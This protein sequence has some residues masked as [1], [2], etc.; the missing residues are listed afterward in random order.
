MTISSPADEA[1]GLDPPGQ[2]A[3]LVE[4]VDACIGMRSGKRF[5][6]PRR[7]E[8]IQRLDHGRAFVPGQVLA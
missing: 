4:L 8:G 1:A 3:A 2:D 7:L 6:R 5:Q